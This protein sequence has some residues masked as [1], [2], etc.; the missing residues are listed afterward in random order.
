M[1]LSNRKAFAGSGMIAAICLLAGS[2]AGHSGIAIGII[3]LVLFGFSYAVIEL[4]GPMEVQVQF[5]DS[6]Y[7]SPLKKLHVRKRIHAFYLYLQGLGLNP[8]KISPIINIGKHPTVEYIGGM[9]CAGRDSDRKDQSAIDNSEAYSDAAIAR[10]YSHCYFMRKTKAMEFPSDPE[11]HMKDTGRLLACMV[12]SQYFC[13]AFSGRGFFS[14]SPLTYEKWIS[15]LLSIRLDCGSHFT[16][17]AMTGV[18]F[19]LSSTPLIPLSGGTEEFGE[20]FWRRLKASMMS[21]SFFGNTEKIDLAREKL[22]DR[23][24]IQP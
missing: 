21:I 2:I 16:D 23:G 13:L 3:M 4:Q 1:D 8:P 18:V 9:S 24:L 10:A 7:L 5:G 15:A 19:D 20:W 12:I 17:S 14:P 11:D 6:E 22:L